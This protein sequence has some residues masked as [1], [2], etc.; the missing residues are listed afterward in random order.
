MSGDLQ[1]RRWTSQGT[2][3]R[4]YSPAGLHWD[5]SFST[6]TGI[7][8]STADLVFSACHFCESSGEGDYYS[9]FDEPLVEELRLI[10]AL[11]L[12][13]GY[14]CGVLPFY[15]LLSSIRLEEYVSLEDKMSIDRI[16]VVLR[17]E[18]QPDLDTPW[19][20][21]PVP[22]AFGGKAYQFREGPIPAGIAL[23]IYNAI[24]PKDF[25]L[26][27]GLGAF[28]RAGMLSRHHHLFESAHHALFV[29]LE[30]SF[31][32]VLRKLRSEGISNPSSAHAAELVHRT[33]GGEGPT[34]GYF[35]DYYEDRIQ[36]FH[37]SS[38]FGEAPYAPLM[39]SHFYGL[40]Y[41]LRDVFRWLILGERLD[42]QPDRS[43][44]HKQRMA[45]TAG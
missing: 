37:P 45:A 27:R 22:P 41:D 26:M 43:D 18:F 2:I 34:A 19:S 1:H 15:P 24:D 9:E 42:L 44:R 30:A 14:A 8:V 10:A 36:L 5:T 11:I 23:R 40:Y 32:L 31:Q 13:I 16:S 7:V 12:P 4:P 21:G 17:S 38:R 20:D 6:P 39:H 29:A 33:F 3:L 25:V 28:I 35:S